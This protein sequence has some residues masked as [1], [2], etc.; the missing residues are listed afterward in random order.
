M[1]FNARQCAEMDRPVTKERLLPI[2]V[3]TLATMFLCVVS[4]TCRADGLP[5]IEPPQAVQG[6]KHPLTPEEQARKD[7]LREQRAK[8]WG[9]FMHYLIGGL[10]A[11]HTGGTLGAIVTPF[12]WASN[13]FGSWLGFLWTVGYDALILMLIFTVAGLVG[14]CYLAYRALRWIFTRKGQ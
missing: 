8:R 9:I 7:H 12:A 4:V 3:I 2:C 10:A 6:R 13:L 11:S 14:C 1:G 5:L